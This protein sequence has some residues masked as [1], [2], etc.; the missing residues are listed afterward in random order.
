[1]F[2]IPININNEKSRILK[3]TWDLNPLGLM[4]E[5][6]I[7]FHFELYDNDVLNGPKKVISNTLKLRLPSLNDLFRSFASKED[8]ITDFVRSEIKILIIYK[9]N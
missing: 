7:N 5:D 4:P 2:N 3:T 9:S 1:M 8:E 6:E